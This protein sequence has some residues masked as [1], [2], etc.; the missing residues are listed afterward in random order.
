M[1]HDHGHDH[2]DHVGPNRHDAAFAIGV[3]LNAALVV[4]QI[5]F[6]LLAGSLALIADAGH[7]FGDVLGLALAWWAATLSRRPPTARR[8]YGYGRSSILASL[9]NAAILLV[10]VGAIALEAIRRL[11]APGPVAGLTVMWVA[12]AAIAVN[13]FTALLFMRGRERDLNIRGAFVHMAADAGVSSGVVVAAVLIHF[14]GWVRLDPLMG[15]V[16]AVV[17]AASSWSLLRQSLHMA[18]D[19][20]PEGLDRAAVEAWLHHLPGVATV[21]DLHIWSLSTTE[22]AL[23]VHLVCP[24]ALPDDRALGAAAAGLAERF[25]IGHATFQVER[26]DPAHPCALAPAD[27]I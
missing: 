2:L 3:G 6:G 7:N 16:I 25:G 22:T 8:T 19:G 27:V 18:M 24:E 15:L 12:L 5:G 23:T 20:V 21:H 14:T 4:A 26:G 10:G 9:A 17:I 13:G 1:P 11:V